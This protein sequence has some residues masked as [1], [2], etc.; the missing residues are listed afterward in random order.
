MGDWSK[1]F[2]FTAAGTQ[3]AKTDG[4]YYDDVDDKASGNS[5]YLEAEDKV[6]KEYTEGFKLKHYLD[7]EKNSK[8]LE[9]LYYGSVLTITEIPEQYEVTIKV[10]GTEIKD[11]QKIYD[12]QDATKLTGVEVTVQPGMEIEF[13]NRYEVT[14]DTGIALDSLP[15][16]LI[17]AIV[18]VGG[19]VLFLRKR[20]PQDD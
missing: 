9:N 17:I 15:Y 7:A 4:T 12:P 3:Y 20:K 5:N 13:T 16:I 18:V 1:L 8:T 19:A 2:D 14:I 10:N 11:A 6:N